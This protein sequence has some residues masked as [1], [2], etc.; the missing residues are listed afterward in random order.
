MINNEPFTT[1]EMETIKI[2]KNEKKNWIEIAKHFKGNKRRTP[3]QCFKAFR[4]KRIL[5]THNIYTR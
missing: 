4:N 5:M 3:I 2:L 1:Q